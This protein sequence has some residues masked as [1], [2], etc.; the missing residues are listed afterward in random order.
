MGN[1][2][3]QY[4]ITVEKEKTNEADRI[5][6]NGRT[7][8]LIK[9]AFAD[10]FCERRLSTTRGQD[11]EHNKYFGQSSTLMRAHRSTEGDLIPQFDQN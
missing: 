5:L 6:I 9:N 11:L 3:L 4:E 2:Y 7:F 1:A 8:S 10:C